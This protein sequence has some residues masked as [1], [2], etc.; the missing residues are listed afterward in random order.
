MAVGSGRST[1]G[2]QIEKNCRDFRYPLFAINVC[3][4]A[5]LPIGSSLDV[6]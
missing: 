2:S 1:P 6:L 4:K 5:G 3:D